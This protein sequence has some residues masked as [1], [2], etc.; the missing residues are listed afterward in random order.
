MKT[1]PFTPIEEGLIFTDNFNRPLFP[2]AGEDEYIISRFICDENLKDL[3]DDHMTDALHDLA[4]EYYE[5][6]D[7]VDFDSEYARLEDLGLS[8]DEFE[9]ALYD[10]QAEIDDVMS[11]AELAAIKLRTERMHRWILKTLGREEFMRV[12]TWAVYRHR[13][14]LV[15]RGA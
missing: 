8:E 13:V 2:F 10:L 4:R 6:F 7:G 12:K 14:I 5:M 15:V 3:F 11:K 9:N 1:I